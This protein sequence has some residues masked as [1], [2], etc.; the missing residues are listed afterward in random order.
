M[1]RKEIPL[2]VDRIEGIA[3]GFVAFDAGTEYADLAFDLLSNWNPRI[4]GAVSAKF[5]KSRIRRVEGAD[6]DALLGALRDLHDRD[7]PSCDSLIQHGAFA[8]QRRSTGATDKVT[9]VLAIFRHSDVE[10]VVIV[11][12]GLDVTYVPPAPAAPTAPAA[13]AV[14]AAPDDAVVEALVRA[15]PPAEVAKLSTLGDRIH[16]LA[17]TPRDDA[18]AE[19]NE[20]NVARRTVWGA[21]AQT[22]PVLSSTADGVVYALL[23]CVANDFRLRQAR[24]LELEEKPGPQAT[25]ADQLA[26]ATAPERTLS[27]TVYFPGAFGR[28]DILRVGEDEYLGMPCT[29]EPEELVRPRRPAV[30][31]PAPSARTVATPRPTEPPT[32][33]IRGIE[34][35]KRRPLRMVGYGCLAWFA[36]SL[37]LGI[38][39]ALLG[40]RT[41][42]APDESIPLSVAY[43]ATIESQSGVVGAL[44]DR[45]QVQYTS[46]RLVAGRFLTPNDFE[47]TAAPVMVVSE[48][49]VRSL[50]NSSAAIVGHTTTVNGQTVTIVGVVSLRNPDTR[51]DFWMPAR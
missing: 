15:I 7:F 12:A 25:L 19:L 35:F 6:L 34:E 39:S 42:K 46:L 43:S 20:A 11:G 18:L 38:A 24:S 21:Q 36:L 41:A 30:S 50:F 32:W 27:I 47:A 8:M 2:A 5:P 37:L 1:S 26:G 4:A 40:S 23:R 31:S 49:L 45:T 10:P 44:V 28:H 29:F 3:I 17:I 16:A 14:P 13:T 22:I 33:L 51:T 9:V 48:R